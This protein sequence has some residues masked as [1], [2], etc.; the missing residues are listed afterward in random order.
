MTLFQ[1]AGSGGK[2]KR[3]CETLTRE[4]LICSLGALPCGRKASCRR[5]WIL[6]RGTRPSHH[7]SQAVSHPGASQESGIAGESPTAGHPRRRA[8]RLGKK[9]ASRRGCGWAGPQGVSSRS[10]RQQC[11]TKKVP[12]VDRQDRGTSSR[13]LPCST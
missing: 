9:Q 2:A 6:G 3:A 10:S 12:A 7:S 1:A 4:I 8:A 13:L 5:L 11:H